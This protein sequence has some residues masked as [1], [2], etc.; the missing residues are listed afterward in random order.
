[1]V[2]KALSVLSAREV[3]SAQGGLLLW[4]S[5]RH[6]GLIHHTDR[7][8]ER[9]LVTGS[10]STSGGPLDC[11]TNF[12]LPSTPWRAFPGPLSPQGAEWEGASVGRGTSARTMLACA[13]EAKIAK[14]CHAK[15]KMNRADWRLHALIAERRE[16]WKSSEQRLGENRGGRKME[17]QTQN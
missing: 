15:R 12:F 14:A 4:S 7:K 8:E 13:A 10:Q 6:R 16:S 17:K 3:S 9:R 2:P 5:L 11:E 1:M